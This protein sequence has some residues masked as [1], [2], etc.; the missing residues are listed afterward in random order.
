MQKPAVESLIQLPRN[1]E[2]ESIGSR[3]E[4]TGGCVELKA[5]T[6]IRRIRD[7]RFLPHKKPVLTLQLHF[8]DQ[9]G[10]ETNL[11][12]SFSSSIYI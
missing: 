8:T 11:I 4:S 6:E 9:S 12:I 10:S 5:V 3:P 1:L 2:A 7:K